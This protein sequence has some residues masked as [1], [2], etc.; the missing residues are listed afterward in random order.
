MQKLKE[1]LSDTL[2]YGISSVLARFIG[3]LLVPLHTSGVFETSEYGIVSLVYAGLVFLNVIFTFG[4]ES[5]YLRY[6][7]DRDLAK[8]VFKTL[9]TG[10]AGL[11][12]ILVLLLI[13]AAP[14]LM[15]TINLETSGK[16]ILDDARNT[17]V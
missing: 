2:V 5:A 15:P 6:A 9:Q 8:D 1:L 10:L 13:F 14:L 7:K 12:S 16:Q 4:M 17:L 11:S 3:Y